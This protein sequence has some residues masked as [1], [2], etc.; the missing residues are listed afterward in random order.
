MSE[1]K[2]WDLT[3]DETAQLRQ[4]F[5]RRMGRNQILIQLQEIEGFQLEQDRAWWNA[6]RKRHEIPEE[7]KYKLL[8]DHELGKVWV[9]PAEGDFRAG[10]KEAG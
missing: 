1:P 3:A 8:A 6:V 10:R 2:E 4:S 7:Y 9:K 5:L